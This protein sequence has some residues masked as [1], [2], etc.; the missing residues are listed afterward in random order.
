MVDWKNPANC[1]P[2]I[3]TT[4]VLCIGSAVIVYA[5]TPGTNAR[6]KLEENIEISGR[7][8]SVEGM[9]N[10]HGGDSY[11]SVVMDS[12]GRKVLSGHQG[13]LYPN[14]LTEACALIRSEIDDGDREEIRVIGRYDDNGIFKMSRIERVN[15]YDINFQSYG[16]V[17]RSEEAE[18]EE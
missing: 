12:N 16:S 9:Q 7:P 11:V 2:A 8:L 1:I 4:A 14:C 6:S 15:G 10:G 13:F 18:K 5:F 17:K 3:I